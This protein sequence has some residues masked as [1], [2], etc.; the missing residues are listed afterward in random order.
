ME[1]KTSKYF[2]YAIGEIVLV[3][4]GILIALQ[5]NNWNESRKQVNTQ[6]AIYLIVKEDLET[7]ISEF[8]LFIQ[9]YNKLQKPAFDAVLNKELTKE[10]WKNNPNYMKVMY[11]YEDIGISQRGID[12]LKII[13]DFSNNLGQGL[14][15]DINNFYN[16]HM[17]EVNISTDELGK[18]HERNYIY[19]QSFGWYASFLMQ[20]KTDGFID[21]FYKDPTIKSRIAT[22][23]F[24]FRIYI[25]EL[26]NYITNA[27][28]LIV[29][30]DYHLKE[31]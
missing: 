13:S 10:D 1:N 27:N 18:Q 23:Y 24:I 22:Y 11:G 31:I 6:N 5:I 2:K 29:K 12:Q 25:K 4:I 20:N 21:S 3:V 17:L 30:I 7:D 8:E 16:K 19:F 15:S 14:T 28:A 9:E 26:Q